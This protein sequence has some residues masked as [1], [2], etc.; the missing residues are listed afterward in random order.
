MTRKMLIMPFCANLVQ[1]STTSLLSSMDAFVAAFQ[2]DVL[3]D[4]LH[5]MICAG[6][7]GLRRC[8]REP[9]D[10]RAAGHQA[11]QE[12]RVQNR[13][14]RQVLGEAVGENHDD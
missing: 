7:Y 4:E 11:E 8:A 13:Q 14:L 5:G 2:L 6:R 3:L 9:V 12:R 1:I 10:N